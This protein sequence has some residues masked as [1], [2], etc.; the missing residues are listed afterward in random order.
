MSDPVSLGL[1]AISG[2]KA[3]IDITKTLAD[4][5]DAVKLAQTR[6]EL[7]SLLVEAQESAR[8]AARRPPPKTGSLGRF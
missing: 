3:A 6:V 8:I 2:L 5:R 1:G 4:V 7:L